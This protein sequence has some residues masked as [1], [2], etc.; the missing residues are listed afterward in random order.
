M[1]YLKIFLVDLNITAAAVLI[2]LIVGFCVM[3]VTIWGF[4]TDAI[5]K[6]RRFLKELETEK[7]KGTAMVMT[8][9]KQDG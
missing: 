9:G 6:K 8:G 4:I 1:D 3:F 5:E 2:A 7:L